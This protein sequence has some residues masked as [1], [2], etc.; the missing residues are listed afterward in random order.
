MN[1]IS[2]VMFQCPLFG[3]FKCT[4]TVLFLVIDFILI[5]TILNPVNGLAR[6]FVVKLCILIQYPQNTELFGFHGHFGVV[7]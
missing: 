4:L 2:L 3:F 5:L 1:D 6:H 7:Y